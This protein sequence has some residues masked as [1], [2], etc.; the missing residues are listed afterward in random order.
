MDAWA[1]L[2]TYQGLPLVPFLWRRLHIRG[3]WRLPRE[4]PSLVLVRRNDPLM[5]VLL[6]RAAVPAFQVSRSGGSRRGRLLPGDDPRFEAGPAGPGEP[7][8]R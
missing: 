8:P 5:D 4:G 2:L 6:V 3:A 7:A 1:R